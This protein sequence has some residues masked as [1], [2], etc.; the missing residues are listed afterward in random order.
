MAYG[1]TSASVPACPALVNVSSY[2]C[3]Y[4]RGLLLLKHHLNPSLHPLG[5]ATRGLPNI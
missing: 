1:H 4:Q 2:H 5:A 3:C